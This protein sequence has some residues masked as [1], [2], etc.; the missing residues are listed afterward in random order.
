MFE[1]HQLTK[2][3]EKG[4]DRNKNRK[5]KQK[6]RRKVDGEEKNKILDSIPSGDGSG[7]REM[8]QGARTARTFECVSGREMGK[9]A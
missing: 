1:K 3:S 9:S 2:K 5:Q 8:A 6:K 7:Q 4:K